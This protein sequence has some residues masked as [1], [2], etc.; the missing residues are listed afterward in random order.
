MSSKLQRHSYHLVDLSPWPLLSSL[1]AVGLTVGLVMY[2]HRVSFGGWVFSMS[3]I[4]L[5]LVM[6]VWWRD[7][8][9]EGTYLGFH[10]KYVQAGLKYG[11][12]LFIVSEVMF[13]FAFFW[14]FFHSSL[15][16]SIEIG[17]IWPPLGIEV[18]DAGAMPFLNT[19]I[20]L[21]SGATV[22]RAHHGLRGGEHKAVATYLMHTCLLGV[23]FTLMQ[24]L[25]YQDSMFSISDGVYG[26]TFFMTTGFHGFHVLVGTTFLIVCYFRQVK[27]HFLANHHLGF[28]AAAW[29]WHFVDVVWL[30][31]FTFVYWWGGI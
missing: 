2:M 30:F 21:L 29:Y 15:A 3:F 22:T 13:F 17:S 14:G 19:M 11:V 7:V 23:V 4:S 9:R 24:L 8:V 12:I 20:L 25:E 26:S 16:P 31:L 5:L 18:L 27:H 6:G 1:N 10:T 28:E